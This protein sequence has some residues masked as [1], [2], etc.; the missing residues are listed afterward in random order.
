[1]TTLKTLLDSWMEMDRNEQTRAELQRLWDDGDTDELEKR[2]RNRIE[3]G[4]AGLRGRM[5][6]GWARMNDLI[7]IQA[8]QVCLSDEP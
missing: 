8:S 7:I 4:T 2:L 6:A 5:E 3:F 1:M